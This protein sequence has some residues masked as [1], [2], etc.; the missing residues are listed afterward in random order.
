MTIIEN[1]TKCFNTTPDDWKF[2]KSENGSS[3]KIIIAGPSR[4]VGLLDLNKFDEEFEWETYSKESAP[5]KKMAGNFVYNGGMYSIDFLRR[6]FPMLPETVEVAR[7]KEGIFFKLTDDV[8]LGLAEKR[9]DVNFY[10]NNEGVMFVESVWTNEKGE[11]WLTVPTEKEF[12][13]W[14]G[15]MAK[16]KHTGK[17]HIWYEEVYKF[18]NFFEE[19][20]EWGDMMN[21]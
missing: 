20:E 10:Y 12:I 3:D 21:P 13:K 19:E 14:D 4:I 6:M 17:A 2:W 16:R 9:T 8:A 15:K 1:F 5:N 18:E 11:T 7:H